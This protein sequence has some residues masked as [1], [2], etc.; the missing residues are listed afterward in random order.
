MVRVFNR[1]IELL[2]SRFNQDV[3]TTEDSIRYTFF[4]ALNNVLNIDP[5]DVVL[6]F[7][8]NVGSKLDCYLPNYYTGF[9]FK[10]HRRGNVDADRTGQAGSV[11]KDI[12]RLKRFV[13]ESKL[14]RFL[15]YITDG[16]MGDYFQNQANRLNDF[17]SLNVNERLTI[18]DAYVNSH[19]DTFIN[20]AGDVIECDVINCVK[21]DNHNLYVRIFRII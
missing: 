18:D 20:A 2:E 12:F 6:E 10:Y 11:F 7:P 17:F 9:E 3:H 16:E 13:D 1:F 15:I 21:Y 14:L 5:S 19:A 8:F 4:Y